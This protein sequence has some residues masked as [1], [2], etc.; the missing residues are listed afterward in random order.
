VILLNPDIQPNQPEYSSRQDA[1]KQ[2]FE[3]LLGKEK[4]F[5]QFY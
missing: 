4:H 1:R 2:S 3:P 5:V